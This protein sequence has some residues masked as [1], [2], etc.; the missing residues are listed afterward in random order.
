LVDK[1]QVHGLTRLGQAMQRFSNIFS[2]SQQLFPR[3]E[4]EQA[5][6][7]HRSDY[8]VKDLTSCGQ[9]IAMLFCQFGRSHSLSEIYFGHAERAKGFYEAAPSCVL[10]AI[11]CASSL[12]LPIHA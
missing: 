11:V 10:A 2:Q 9:F 4:V 12:L 7:K 3:Y 5:V 6:Q 8:S 1:Y